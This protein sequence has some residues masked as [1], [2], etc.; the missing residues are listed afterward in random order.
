MLV[1]NTHICTYSGK[2]IDHLNTFPKYKYKTSTPPS[3][4]L[5]PRDR[6]SGGISCFFVLSVILSSSET[7]TLL[8]T[9]EQWVLEFWYFTWEFLVIRSFR[10]YHFVLP[11]DLDFNLRVWPIFWKLYLAY[12]FWTVSARALVYYMSILCDKTFQWVLD[13]LTLT[14]DLFLFYNWH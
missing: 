3:V 2:L 13:L 9:F 10:G 5:C 4:F 11:C 8:I 12:N 7:L 14:F 6:R 1:R